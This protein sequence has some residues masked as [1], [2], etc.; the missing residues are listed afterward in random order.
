[1]KKASQAGIKGF[2]QQKGISVSQ[3]SEILL[4]EEATKSLECSAHEDANHV[5]E[6][7]LKAEVTSDAVMADH[8]MSS[9]TSDCGNT[10]RL[11]FGVGNPELDTDKNNLQTAFDQEVLLALAEIEKDTRLREEIALNAILNSV[12]T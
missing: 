8:A 1:M 5:E 2:I 11:V 10:P 9:Q 3:S 7:S 6:S 12:Y 4:H